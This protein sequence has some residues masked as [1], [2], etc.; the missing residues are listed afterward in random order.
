WVLYDRL[1]S[2][3]QPQ[4]FVAEHPCIRRA[5]I[6]ST[7]GNKNPF[8]IF[9]LP[10]ILTRFMNS[11]ITVL[12][13]TFVKLSHFFLRISNSP[14]VLFG[15]LDWGHGHT[16]R[17]LPLIQALREEHLEVV[18]AGSPWQQRIVRDHFP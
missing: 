18:F 15:A 7:T 13:A 12:Y 3:P 5:N 10:C 11:K 2:E 1:I 9:F 16:T 17:S 4:P 8:F 14:R 6:A